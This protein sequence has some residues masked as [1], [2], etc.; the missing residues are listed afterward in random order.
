MLGLKV[1]S[2]ALLLLLLLFGHLLL[3]QKSIATFSSK[4]IS[5][6]QFLKELSDQSKKA[7]VYSADRLPNKMLSLRNET[8]SFQEALAILQKQDFSTIEKETRLLIVYKPRSKTKGRYT[9]AGYIR[10]KRSGKVLIGATVRIMEQNIGSVTNR[11]GYYSLTIPKGPIVLQANYV[12]YDS[13]RLELAITQNQ[14]ADFELTEKSIELEEVTVSSRPP[15][16]NVESIVPGINTMNF[17]S[18]NH[19]P[20]FMG[21]VDIFQGALTLP[22]IKILGEE[23][24]GLNVRG[25]AIDENLILLDEAPIYNPNHYFGLISVFNPEAVNDVQFFKGFFPANYGG[26][27]SSVIT[28]HQREGNNEEVQFSGGL[29]LLSARFV[30]E[31]PIKKNKS[32]FLLS[33]RQSL[34]NPTELGNSDVNNTSTFFTDFNAKAN[35]RANDN[36]TFF[37]SGYLGNDRSVTGFDGERRWG[38]RTLTFRWNRQK[39]NRFFSHFSAVFSEYNYRI[40]EPREAGSFIGRFRIIDYS[41]KLD[42][43]F[44]ISPQSRFDY[45]LSTTFHRLKPGERLPFDPDDTATNPLELDSEHGIESGAYISNEW[46]IND[47][48]STIAGLRLSSL[49]NIGPADVYVYAAD[50]PRSDQS[51]VDTLNI[52]VREIFKE[53]YNLEPRMAINLRA[54]SSAAIKASYNRTYQYIHLISNTITPN[55]TDIWK[56][57]DDFIAPTRTDHFSLGYYKN[58]IEN[59]WETY[60]DLYFKDIRNTIEYKD[61]ADLVF[62]ENIETELINADARAYGLELFIKRNIGRTNGWLSYT[63]SRAERRTITDFPEEQINDGGYFPDDNDKTHDISLVVQHKISNR[64]STSSTF[65]YSTGRPITL[66]V[67][68]YDFEGNPIPHFGGRNR[69]RITDYHRLD[70]SLRLDGKE[71]KKDGSPRKFQ[72]YWTL[73][74]YNVYARRNAFSYFF[75]ASEE[76]PNET[77][78]VRYSVFGTIIPSITYNFRF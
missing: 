68:R 22:G 15:S 43:S 61:G 30:A 39:R 38:N 12:G 55:P 71:L 4:Y 20:Y 8:I 67:G 31:G 26:R 76:N 49:H 33:G 66:P 32:S 2:A 14:K 21:E 56:L 9:I 62:N 64:L 74:V 50:Q 53:F 46:K 13:L 72:D 54:S 25:G 10:D 51:I 37:I 16:F 6:E 59:A 65:N 63:L 47:R 36:N 19:L 29:G 69:S 34:L 11:Y 23:A 5:I 40:V 75:R 1:K 17:D 45:G 77:E 57:S 7:L 58:F 42:E 18:E 28:V 78:V 73:S 60:V 3:A 70:F 35:W 44:Y 48:L 52:G 41:L 24:S 27:A